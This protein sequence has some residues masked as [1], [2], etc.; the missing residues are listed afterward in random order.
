MKNFLVFSFLCCSL[1]T[2]SQKK[3]NDKKENPELIRI[4]NEK[5][6]VQ[7]ILT[8]TIQFNTRTIDSLKSIIKK[9]TENKPNPAKKKTE[10]NLSTTLIGENQWVTSTL[11]ASTKTGIDLEN[12]IDTW[13]TENNFVRCED[14][15]SWNE[16]ID[17]PSYLVRPGLVGKL[18]YYF[19]LTAIRKMTSLL[20]SQG[21]WRIASNNDF[22]ALF[23]HASALKLGSYSPF[24]LLVGNPAMKEMKSLSSWKNQT[25]YD[26]Y[27]LQITPYSYY[28]G[29]D[30]LLI[31][32]NYVEYFSHFTESN[33]VFVTHIS[34][35]DKIEPLAYGYGLE[36]TKYGF[37][38]RLIKI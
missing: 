28:S 6:S 12:S 36:A 31:N 2:F 7:Q 18:G 16:N 17:N 26:I 30:K 27:G 21:Q 1:I 9:K 22:N 29:F 25:V 4:Q 14:Q 23:K 3:K 20:E 11:G 38:I 13:L 32:D 33:E 10:L 8:F 24:Q 35:E 34:P 37:F 15:A 19:N 5:D